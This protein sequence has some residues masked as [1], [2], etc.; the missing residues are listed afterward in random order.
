MDRQVKKL[1]MKN[2]SHVST[3]FGDGGKFELCSDVS[4]LVVGGGKFQLSSHVSMFSV[5]FGLNLLYKSFLLAINIG[6]RFI[7]LSCQHVVM[8]ICVTFIVQV[9][10]ACYQYIYKNT[11]SVVVHIFQMS[12]HLWHFPFIR[13]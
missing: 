3:F 12:G 10:F 7:V 6:A 2:C 1:A 4:T 5:L 11:K 13:Q 8:F 9:I